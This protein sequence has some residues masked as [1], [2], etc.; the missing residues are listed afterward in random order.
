MPAAFR[1]TGC[2]R[3]IIVLIGARLRQAVTRSHLRGWLADRR[4]LLVDGR[5]Q[6]GTPS[7]ARSD[8]NRT[9]IAMI[10]VLAVSS[11]PAR[12]SE[13]AARTAPAVHRHLS[14]S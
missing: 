2:A 5:P 7:Q 12:L 6:Y 1:P 14:R 9:A 10:Y 8:E 3:S 13:A 11:H 4:R